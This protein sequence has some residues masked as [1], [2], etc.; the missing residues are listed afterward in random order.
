MKK[1]KKGYPL[2]R[3]GKL[4]H[5]KVAE[6]KIGRPLRKHEVV[7]HQDENKNNFRKDNLSVMSRSFHSKLHGKIKRRK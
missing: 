7:H 1:N 2:T 4:M 6:N 5:R 3:N